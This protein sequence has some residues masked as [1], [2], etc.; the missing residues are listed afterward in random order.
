MT[1]ITNIEHLHILQWCIRQCVV[2]CV[3]GRRRA[4]TSRMST[5]VDAGWRAVTDVDVRPLADVNVRLDQSE[6]GHGGRP[7]PLPHCVRWEPSCPQK[8]H[9][10]TPI[11]GLCLL[12]PNGCR[13]QLLM[14]E[15]LLVYFKAS[16]LSLQSA[17]TMDDSENRLNCINCCALCIDENVDNAVVLNSNIAYTIR[18]KEETTFFWVQLFNTWLKL[19]NFVTYIKESISYNSMYLIFDMH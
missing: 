19:M 1:L 9:V 11:F 13:S 17:T 15:H 18:Q 16:D 12:W 2:T 5:D 8:G 3:D 10:Q 14:I 6:T 4:F 7:R